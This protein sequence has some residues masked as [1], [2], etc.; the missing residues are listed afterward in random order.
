MGTKRQR[1]ESPERS[2]PQE[3]VDDDENDDPK[4]PDYI[5]EASS[6]AVTSSRSSSQ[7]PAKKRPRKT[8]DA[9]I[10][11]EVERTFQFPEIV[12]KDRLSTIFKLE[13]PGKATNNKKPY[14]SK[15]DRNMIRLFLGTA[16]NLGEA[17]S[18]NFWRKEW[19]EK[20]LVRKLSI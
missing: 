3:K 14:T 6:D 5:P 16:K 13:L 9:T 10:I 8:I 15:T 11:S 1:E 4:D 2:G 17:F 18:T 19:F 20:K 7:P 12:D